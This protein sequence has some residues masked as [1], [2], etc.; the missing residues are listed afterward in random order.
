MTDNSF[1]MLVKDGGAWY[2]NLGLVRMID[3]VTTDHCRLWF[4]ENHSVE[5]SGPAVT[6]VLQFANSGV[7]LPDGSRPKRA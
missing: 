7:M 1:L 6:A 5:V 2:L 3:E 4:D